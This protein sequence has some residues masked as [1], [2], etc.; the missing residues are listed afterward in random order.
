MPKSDSIRKRILEVLRTPTKVT[1]LKKAIPEVSSFGTINYWL[2]K[3]ESEHII[4]KKKFKNMQGKPTV[5][6]LKDVSM[7]KSDKEL[8][9]ERERQDKLEL[10]RMVKLIANKPG[11]SHA[12]FPLDVLHSDA[13]TNILNEGLA[14]MKCYLTAKGKKFLGENKSN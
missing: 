3:L 1:D 5:Y 13:P 4:K 12:D 8:L 10:L 14:D 11:R 7:E 2:R 6:A 9:E